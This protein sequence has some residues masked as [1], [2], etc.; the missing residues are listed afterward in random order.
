M[1]S[2]STVFQ[3]LQDMSIDELVEELGVN[4]CGPSSILW[5]AASA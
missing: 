2:L 5:R 1:P 4:R 3:N